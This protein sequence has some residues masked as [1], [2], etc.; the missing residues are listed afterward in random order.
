MQFFSCSFTQKG[1]YSYIWTLIA[2]KRIYR[3]FAERQRRFD[4]FEALLLQALHPAMNLSVQEK[5]ATIRKALDTGD[6]AILKATLK[7]INGK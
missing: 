2:F 7:Q 6:K 5:A 1:I 3:R 4:K